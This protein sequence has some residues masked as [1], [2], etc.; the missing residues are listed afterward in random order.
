V[1]L[2]TARSPSP[3]PE[4]SRS[5]IAGR[6]QAIRVLRQSKSVQT[7]LASDQATGQL[8]FVKRIAAGG[9][10]AGLL[11]RLEHEA[12]GL[13]A[14]NCPSL[15]PL[16]AVER[17]ADELLLVEEAVTGCSLADRLKS[18]PLSVVETLSL[19]RMLL[20]GLEV[21]HGHRI[22]HRSLRPANVILVERESWPAAVLVGFGPPPLIASDQNDLAALLETAQ[23]ISPELA[24]LVDYDVGETS[25]L[26]SVGAVLFHCL[27]GRPPFCGVSV[28]AVLL[29][30]MTSRVPELRTLDARIPRAVDELVHRLLRQDPHERYQSAEATLADLEAIEVQLQA[31]SAEPTVVIGARDRRGKLTEPAFVARQR[32]LG[33]MTRRLDLAR[34]GTSGLILVE[35]ESGGGKSRLLAE[36]AHRGACAGFRVFRGQ[37]TSAV[38]QH[39]FQLLDGL[40]DGIGSTA[41]TH[42][43][44]VFDIRDR[45]SPEYVSAIRSALPAL[46]ELWPGEDVAGGAP[47]SAGELRVLQALTELL[48]ALGSVDQPALVILDD[49]QWADD[50]TLKLLRRWQ[51][52]LDESVGPAGHLVLVI[53]FRADEVS[54]QHALRKLAPHVHLSLSPLEADEVRQLVESMAGPLPDEAVDLIVRLADGSPFMASAVLRGLVESQALLPEP[55]GWRLERLALG[56]LQSSNRAGAFLARRL[57]LLP[58]DAVLLLQAGA[59]L[60]KEFSLDVA[61]ALSGFEAATAI[62]QLDAARERRLVWVRPD[63]GGCVFV[64]DKIRAAILDRLTEDARR[65]MHHRAAEHFRQRAPERVSD[66]AYHYDEAGDSHRAL[67]YALKAAEE[68]RHRH[69][70]AIAEQQYRIAERGG[71]S[72]DS[73]TRYRIAEGLGDALMLMGRYDEAGRE[74]ER[75]AL[76]AGSK[77]AQAQIRGKIA[78]LRFKRGD[79]ERALV[80]FE[81]ALVLLGRRVPKRRP[82]VLL[83]LVWEMLIQLGHTL[84]P[85]LWLHR[86][87]R[88]PTAEESQAL[89]LYSN[90]AHSC[91]YCRDLM[92]SMW[93]HLRGMNLAERLEPSP[94]LANAWAEHAPAMTL[95]SYFSRAIRYAERSLAIRKERGD[96]WGQGHTRHYHGV[97]LYASARYEE[98]IVKCREAVR[99][100][101][102]MGDYWQVHIARY[103][104]AASLY[105]LG[106]LSGALEEAKINHLSGLELGDEQASSINLDLWAR[107]VPGGVPQEV[108][109]R[110]LARPR[111]E[112]QGATQLLLA[113]GVTQLQQGQLEAAAETLE[114]AVGVADQAGVR[115]PYTLPVLPWA[116]TAYRRLAEESRDLTPHH[117]RNCL[118]RA[119]QL[120]RQAVWSS[121]LCGNDRPHIFREAALLAALRGQDRRADR[122]FRRS[123]AEA[124]VRQA[125]WELALTLVEQARVGRELGW[126]LDETALAQ[127]ETLLQEHR[128]QSDQGGATDQ[129]E[130]QP[131]ANLSLFDR[132]DTILNDGRAIASELVPRAVYDLVHASALRLLRGEACAVLELTGTTVADG[133]QV[134]AGAVTG[135]LDRPLIERALVARR[136]VSAGR[137]TTTRP[138]TATPVEGSILCVPLLVRQVAVAVVYVTHE[139]VQG[140]FGPEE[141]RIADF[142]AAIAGAALENAEGFAEL[143]RLNATLEERVAERTA[144]AESRSQQLAA[145]NR[146]LERIAQEL[147]EAQGELRAAKLAAEAASEAKSR[148]LATMSHE[149]RT[150]M[151]GVIGMTEL[152]L[153][154]ALSPQQR[155]Y[156]TIVKESAHALL[157]LL[158][159]ILDFSKI[160]AG[161][162]ELEHIP[163]PLADVV[164]DACRLLAVQA[165][166]KSIE[167]VLHLD[168][169]LPPR[170]VGDPVRIRQVIVNLV[171]NALKFTERGEV[172]VRAELVERRDHSATLRLQVRDTGIGIPADKQKSIFEAFRQSDSSTTRRYGGTGLGLSISAQLTSLM[173][174]HISIDSTPGVGSTFQVELTLQ[175]DDSPAE[176]SPL[177]TRSDSTRVLVVAQSSSAR[178]AY[179]EVLEPAGYQLHVA[180]FPEEALLDWLWTADG[181]ENPGLAMI[182]VSPQAGS[183]DALE[184]L[185]TWQGRL[186]TANIPVLALLPAG[187]LLEAEQLATLQLGATLTKPAK[188][189]EILQ[190]IAAL[191]DPD[192][193]LAAAPTASGLA[194]VTGAPLRILLADDS[195]VNQEV[196]A[197]L[198]ELSGH[199]VHCVDDGRAA[200]E[201]WEQSDYDLVFLDMEM[202]EL[203]GLGA[204]RVIRRLER[205]RGGHVPIFAMTAHAGQNYREA[206]LAAGMDGFISKPL[207]PDEVLR[208]VEQARQLLERPS[209]AHLPSAQ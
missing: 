137:Q 19:G 139:H 167:L 104:I 1:P 92:I 183:T 157:S 132:F 45:I 98:C 67:P 177:A 114:R 7:L 63:G 181:R 77:L 105:R 4:Q 108:L 42:P 75:A 162:M 179:R 199:M 74:F 130:T 176:P 205:K 12:H 186:A 119:E 97:V 37:G 135:E 182:D 150:P 203:D 149:I 201:A 155:N 33:E 46:A 89:R 21:L 153:N 161:R 58:H 202:P 25:D 93:S 73:V 127:A 134:T 190:A 85:W 95:I 62:Q 198:L 169:Q 17:T 125:R 113:Q 2:Q 82:V 170:L 31:G 197:G 148:F 172:V 166:R 191:L 5:L 14:I 18:G 47:E 59:V 171:G 50:L 13:S 54:D 124:R 163:F 154:T 168:R 41:A 185:Q 193:V 96:L 34:S 133:L 65:T 29:G 138:G 126:D 80:E 70:L 141:D 187:Q 131:L 79:M 52:V 118:H 160:E 27:S 94:E 144:A 140:L 72:A 84:F 3:V 69:A 32:E 57:D 122:L 49:C 15:A 43:R 6:Y 91:W 11:M 64:H 109:D 158:N 56:D 103:Q 106:D 44:A 180:E 188:P 22:V 208:A 102:R 116:V 28:N 189:Q 184:Q 88:A 39:P 23:Y 209:M 110:E 156:L 151:N 55:A 174:G 10:P 90:L 143:Q 147:R 71:R 128:S 99:L 112:A 20:Q 68:A 76:S 38:A 164:G 159:D 204:T 36:F 129:A 81:A 136:A 207:Q 61:A 60:G 86:L 16:L 121:L 120:I 101:E 83:W 152:A 146:E 48:N 165:A 53:A 196:A 107:C 9:L 206:C 117:R 115:N 142:I 178:E 200:V 87:H 111:H 66:L 173:G 8:V 26:Y 51:R 35:A 123:L 194:A 195:P 100:L 175:L 78:E 30:H 40:A 192:A 24:G 145:S